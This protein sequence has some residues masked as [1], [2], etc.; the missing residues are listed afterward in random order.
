VTPG[1]RR[2]LAA[3][4]L[5]V[6]F[7]EALEP[8]ATLRAFVEEA[9]PAG[10]ILFGRNVA[11]CA[12]VS[13]LTRA[14]RAL[15][16]A[17]GRT[18]LIAIDQEGGRVARLRAP[19]CPEIVALPPMRALGA[20]GD[21]QLT[22][23]LARALALQLA[24]LGVNFDLAPVADVDTNPANPIIGD[25]AFGATP[26]VVA[27][28]AVAFSQGLADGGVLSCGKH[29]PGHGDTHLD[30]HLALPRLG[31]SLERLR[32][33]ELVPFRAL[34][35]AGVPA[36]MTAHIVFEALDPSAPATLSPFVLR[37]L[38]REELGFEGA[39]LSDDLEM[40]AV[41]A[42]TAPQESAGQVVGEAAVR[43]VEA[44]CDG[45]LVCRDLQAARQARDA[46]AARLPVARLEEALGR[47]RALRDAAQDHAARPAPPSLPAQDEAARLLA[48]LVGHEASSPA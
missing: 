11:S 30:S 28:H 44:G 22:R 39:V 8:P 37:P 25:R 32:G 9:P 20:R 1:E 41:A 14:L 42:T 15:W 24:A 7:E 3:E 45:V 48:G 36:L 21:A 34:V 47:M 43:A 6:G 35:E 38:L 26:E 16:P 33:V 19:Q 4:L 12:Q 17:R 5:L 31:H 10:V 27:R 23:G 2:Q 13:A 46:L 29:F 18:P 40:A